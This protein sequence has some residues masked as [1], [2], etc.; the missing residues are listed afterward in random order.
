MCQVLRG[1]AGRCWARGTA[2]LPR[3]GAGRDGAGRDPGRDAGKDDAGRDPGRGAGRN[4][5]RD[6][7]GRGAGRDAGRGAGRDPGRDARLPGS[8]ELA[9][10]LVCGALTRRNCLSLFAGSCE[11]E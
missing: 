11:P 2:A 4:A 1:A 3:R 5:G 7:A 6:D 10:Q 8:P 9:S